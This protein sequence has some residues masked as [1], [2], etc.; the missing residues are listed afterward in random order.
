MGW[1]SNADGEID[2]FVSKFILIAGNLQGDCSEEEM[3]RKNLC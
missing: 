3:R 1:M 2:I